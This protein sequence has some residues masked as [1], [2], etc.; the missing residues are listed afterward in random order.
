M[1]DNVLIHDGE[2][3]P[4]L[5]CES[6]GNV[7][8]SNPFQINLMGHIPSLPQSYK[9]NTELLLWVTLFWGYLIA[10]ASSS[11]AAQTIA[12]S[13][14]ECVIRRFRASEAIHHYREPGFMS[15][16]YRVLNRIADRNN[17]QIR[18]TELK[19][20]DQ[21]KEWCKHWR[22]LW[23][24]MSRIRMRKIG[25]NTLRGWLLPSIRHT[26]VY[27]EILLSTRSKVG[28]HDRGWNRLCLWEAPNDRFGNHEDDDT[29]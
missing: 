22:E 9:G 10:K 5:R 2:G 28:T 17:V 27:E 7:Q 4:V 18:R 16:S 14:E 21:Q 20:M 6:P 15:E 25:T 29:I 3:K 13:Y 19:I 1:W 12:E 24:W 23:R 8:A 26:I 11:I